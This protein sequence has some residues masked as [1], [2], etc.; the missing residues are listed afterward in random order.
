VSECGSI[1]TPPS[2]IFL[3]KVWLTFSNKDFLI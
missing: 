1:Q 3:F 2:G